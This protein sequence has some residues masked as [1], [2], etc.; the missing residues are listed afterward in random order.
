MGTPRDTDGGGGGA[1]ACA[2]EADTPAADDNGIARASSSSRLVDRETQTRA[3]YQSQNDTGNNL[4]HWQLDNGL[5][6]RAFW[7]CPMQEAIMAIL[8]DEL[9]LPYRS[10]RYISYHASMNAPTNAM[11]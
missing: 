11:K 9:H 6:H 7:L 1:A 4:L 8:I 3:S 10:Y 5:V 2:D